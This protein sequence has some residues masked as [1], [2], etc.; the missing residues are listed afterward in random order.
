MKSCVSVTQGKVSWA[1]P[2]LKW[3]EG[4]GLHVLLSWAVRHG[5]T[6][7]KKPS[8]KPTGQMELAL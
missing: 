8:K 7:K 4:Q 3:A 1:T 5:K 2:A 6:W